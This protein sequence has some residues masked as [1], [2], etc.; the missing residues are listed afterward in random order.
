MGFGVEGDGYGGGVAIDNE[1]NVYN[2]GV[3]S[4]TLPTVGAGGP[5][6]YKYIYLEKETFTALNGGTANFYYVKMNV[7]RV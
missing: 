7:R 3:Y 1:G 6:I 5:L 2:A 4:F